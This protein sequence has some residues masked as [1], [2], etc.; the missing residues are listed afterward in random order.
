[1]TQ[2]PDPESLLTV[3]ILI[4]SIF[5]KLEEA[6]WTRRMVHVLCREALREEVT[7]VHTQEL[8]HTMGED[9]Q[10]AFRF[11]CARC[12]KIIRFKTY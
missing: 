2:N 4:S 9:F 3:Q 11:S 6:G 12:P 10:S 5:A 8:R 7:L 1:M